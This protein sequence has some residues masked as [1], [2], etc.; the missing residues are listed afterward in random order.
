MPPPSCSVISEANEAVCVPHAISFGLPDANEAVCVP[1]TVSVG[2][3][4]A[5]EW[6]S[7]IIPPNDGG[8]LY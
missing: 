1:H 6:W 2:L 5:N 8:I 4:D 3:P 7:R